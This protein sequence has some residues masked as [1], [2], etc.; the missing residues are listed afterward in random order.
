[1]LDEMAGNVLA[2]LMYIGAFRDLLRGCGGRGRVFNHTAQPPSIKVA[3]QNNS[4]M[5]YQ[6]IFSFFFFSS[7]PESKRKRRYLYLKNLEVPL[8]SSA[9][10]IERPCTNITSYILKMFSLDMK[11]GGIKWINK[12]L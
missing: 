6:K 1:M 3:C 2:V 7:P 9:Q 5:L 11:L 10:T 4:V 8:A 12:C